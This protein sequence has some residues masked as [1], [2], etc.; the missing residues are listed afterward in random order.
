[1]ILGSGGISIKGVSELLQFQTAASGAVSTFFIDVAE[2][3]QLRLD[4]VGAFTFSQGDVIIEG[5]D[6]DD[7]VLAFHESGV[8][9]SRVW[10]D[11]SDDNLI[12]ENLETG[13]ASIVNVISNVTGVWDFLVSGEAGPEHRLV[14]NSGTGSVI[15]EPFQA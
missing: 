13:V 4:G 9:K 6:V 15:N 10:Y 3:L 11:A 12:V 14:A 7:P 8:A 1:M 5:T 2:N